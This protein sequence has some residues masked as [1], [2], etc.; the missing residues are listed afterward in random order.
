MAQAQL[1]V[2]VRLPWWGRPYLLAMVGLARLGAR[3]DPA[4]VAARIVKGAKFSI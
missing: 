3:V 2:R 4:R 1:T